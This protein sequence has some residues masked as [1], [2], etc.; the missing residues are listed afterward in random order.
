MNL[1]TVCTS[2]CHKFW[3]V[4][5]PCLSTDGTR[6][7]VI[8]CTFNAKTLTINPCMYHE[9]DHKLSVKQW[10]HAVTIVL[11]LWLYFV[12]AICFKIQ[13]SSS[14]SMNWTKIKIVTF[15]QKWE[16]NQRSN[17]ISNCYNHYTKETPVVGENF[18]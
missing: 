4:Q 5:T 6:R 13:N 8:H 9:M 3:P 17:Q 2:I 18:K 16:L 7:T 11:S 12:T 1:T 14:N 15:W 10:C